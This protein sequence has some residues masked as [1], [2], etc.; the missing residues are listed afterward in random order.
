[1]EWKGTGCHCV[2]GDA[3]SPHV[4][5]SL[6]DRDIGS[7]KLRSGILEGSGDWRFRGGGDGG[8][9]SGRPVALDRWSVTVVLKVV[10]TIAIWVKTWEEFGHAKVAEKEMAGWILFGVNEDVFEFDITVD[11]SHVLVKVSESRCDLIGVFADQIELQSASILLDQVEESAT[12]VVAGD[13]E[14][15][16]RG[17]VDTQEAE[18]MLV[19]KVAPKI[20][21]MFE[22]GLDGIVFRLRI[23][24]FLLDN[25]D[26]TD[27]LPP[28]F[29]GVC[30]LNDAVAAKSNR[31]S[32][33]VVADRLAFIVR[34]WLSGL[35]P[36]SEELRGW[37]VWSWTASFTLGSS[38][39]RLVDREALGP[40]NVPGIHPW[41]RRGRMLV[42]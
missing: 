29:E 8:R 39:P 12:N 24:N 27:D 13:A 2:D 25:L 37:G 16:K 5:V 3:E 10:I 38:G 22:F 1:M 6:N 30:F 31:L 4:D 32:N 23:S 18:D 42:L 28:L 9:R 33:D 14:E 40:L 21:F 34:L 35:L 20:D 17:I 41:P 19:S 15:S 36:A 26:S 7:E 11:N